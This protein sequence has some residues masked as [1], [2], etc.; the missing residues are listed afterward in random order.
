MECELVKEYEEDRF[1]LLLG[2]VV[3]L[4]VRDNVLGEGG[5][6][7]VSKAKPLMM[8][9]NPAGMNFC[10]VTDIG[11]QEPFEAMF[12]NGKDPLAPL[13]RE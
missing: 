9:G 4:E 6:L 8:T 12:P 13:Y 1:V 3:R 10:T 2:K 11:Q 5:A 7:D